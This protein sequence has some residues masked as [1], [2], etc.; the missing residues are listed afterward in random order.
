[1]RT[2]STSSQCYNYTITAPEYNNSK[3]LH[4]ALCLLPF[5]YI[6]RG[7]V[8]IFPKILLGRDGKIFFFSFFQYQCT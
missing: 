3:M 5:L 4:S 6:H 8:G 1:M 2:E 7:V